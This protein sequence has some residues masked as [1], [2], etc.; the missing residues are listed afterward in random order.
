[1]PN[2]VEISTEDLK[3]LVKEASASIIKEQVDAQVKELGLDT[4]ENKFARLN[5]NTSVAELNK[6][7]GKE[8]MA[9]LVKALAT[10]D[11]EALATFK[12][13]NETTGSAGAF[14]VP[15]E[16]RA[17]VYRI[18]ED[19]G[20]VAKYATKFPMGSDTMNVPTLASSVT[21]SYPGEATAGTA[22]QPVLAQVQL[23][24][25]TAVGLTV[26]SNELLADANVSVVDLLAT[27]FAEAIAG[28]I[29][30]QGL[31]GSGSPFTG[32]L[33]NT[34]VNT[35]TMASGKDTFSEAT[36]E[37]YRDLITQ[38]KPFA[39]QG[40]GYIMHRTVWA[41]IQKLRTGGT[42]SGDFFGA[43][44]NAVIV[45]NAQGFPSAQAGFLWGYPVFLSDKMPA[46]A[47]T[48][49]STKFVIF[50]NLKHM[51]YGDR[52]S[53]EVKVS[54]DGTVNSVSLFE[55]NQSAVRVIVRHAIAVGLPTAFAVLKTAAN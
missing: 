18:V 40:A 15:E 51:F 49:V 26:M 39:L 7:N 12:A 55:T 27:L 38:I 37:D 16:F 42:D 25:K 6:L 8:K 36:L 33:A 31:T 22:S 13:M 46:I 17:E 41:V 35:V 48:A 10:K 20:L 30:D 45:G 29:D 4:L 14:L 28:E 5:P 3:S 54:T 34:S 19:F 1:M 24:A 2:K 32:I 47:D 11:S 23:L 44:T 53:M 52:G 9:K 43:S 21:V 50:G